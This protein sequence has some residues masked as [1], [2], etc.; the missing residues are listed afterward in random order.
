M[1]LEEARSLFPVLERIAYLNAGTF[2]PLARPVADALRAGVERDL[3][4][5]RTGMPYFEATIA[6]RAELRAAFAG[7][8]GA[9]PEQVALTASTSEG[10]A[11][12]L[13]GLG[14]EPG[15]EIVT[16]T[17][18]HFSL[19]GPLGASPAAVVVVRHDVAAGSG[20]E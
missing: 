1:T 4:E 13:R 12:V 7:L 9:A 5:G 3:V 14:L 11:I 17:D 16:T 10:C 19:L 20:D 8:V 18:E 15:D 6:L 2:G